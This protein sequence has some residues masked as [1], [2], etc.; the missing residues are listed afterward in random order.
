MLLR[1]RPRLWLLAAAMADR[2]GSATA[3][4]APPARLGGRGTDETPWRS[5]VSIRG[6]RLEALR[7]A[8]ALTESEFAHAWA[9]MEA[10]ERRTTHP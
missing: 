8:G 5:V 7:L 1:L 9:R 10:S 4:Q 2:G 3:S 6:A